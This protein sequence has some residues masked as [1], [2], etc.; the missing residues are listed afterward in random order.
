[1]GKFVFFLYFYD[2]CQKTVTVSTRVVL[3]DDLDLCLVTNKPN[4]TSLESACVLL[5]V[6]VCDVVC[7]RPIY[8]P[9]HQNHLIM[10]IWHKQP[11]ADSDHYNHAAQYRIRCK[12]CRV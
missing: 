4:G 9:T 1:M 11:R 12:T 6:E 5:S 7:K 8:G 3:F 10:F 2:F